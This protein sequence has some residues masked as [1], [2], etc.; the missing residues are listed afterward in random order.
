M[1]LSSDQILTAEAAQSFEEK[2]ISP[3]E[4]TSMRLVK[5]EDLNHHRTL[6]AGRSAEWFVEA[7]FIVISQLVD[8]HN[9][10]CLKIH[11]MRF[12]KP[13][14]PGQVVMFKGKL[15]KT[16]KSSFIVH[17]SVK[18]PGSDTNNEIVEGFI[19]FVHV[20]VNGKSKPHNYRVVPVTAEDK[21][22]FEKASLLKR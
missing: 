20:D 10:V 14:K 19:T 7:G 1:L 4:I 3:V 17:V 8:P 16:G 22:L 2:V 21:I 5:S 9:A 11:E 6:Y 13:V 18:V 12:L 15:V